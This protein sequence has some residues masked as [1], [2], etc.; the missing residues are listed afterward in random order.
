MESCGRFEVAPG[1][2][3]GDEALQ[4]RDRNEGNASAFGIMVGRVP[5]AM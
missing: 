3:E 1:S 2:V 5:F 4:G